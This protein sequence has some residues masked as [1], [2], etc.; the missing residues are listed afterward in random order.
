MLALAPGATPFILK[1]DIEGGEGDL[2][3]EEAK[4]FARFPI[5]VLELHDWMLPRAG[6]SR[7]FLRWHAERDRDFV[8]IGE[9]VFSMCNQLL[10]TVG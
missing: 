3:G 2:L 10:P 9:N 5:V 7:A 4:V 1:I 6:T 8:H